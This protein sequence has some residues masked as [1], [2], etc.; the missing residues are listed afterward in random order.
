MRDDGVGFDPAYA[1]KLFVPF[2]TLHGTGEFPG[3]GVGLATVAR[4]LERLGGTCWAESSPGE[5][6]AFHFLLG[7]AAEA[8]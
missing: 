5:G 6:A 4:T 2:E 7:D 1:H 3:A 8:G